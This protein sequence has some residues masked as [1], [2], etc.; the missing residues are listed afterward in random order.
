VDGMAG[1]A[2]WVYSK[3]EIRGKKGERNENEN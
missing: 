1:Q 2:G 3:K